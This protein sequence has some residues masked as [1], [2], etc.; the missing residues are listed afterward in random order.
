M[1]NMFAFYICDTSGFL[2]IM[3]LVKLVINFIRYIVP[4]ILI[5]MTIFDLVK[6]V[7]NP[8]EKDGMNKIIKRAVAAILVF[9]VPAIV[10]ATINLLNY[11]LENSGDT[12]YKV[13][14]CYT[15]A[16]LTCI[17]KIDDYLNCEGLSGD[18]LLNCKRFRQC[19]SYRLVGDCGIVT[20]YDNYS[21]SSINQNSQYNMYSQ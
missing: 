10:G 12:D 2:R 20:E 11:V 19:N 6:N 3:Y 21:C 14:S 13:S 15:N 17:N 18:A 5:V 4:M 16:N 1:F 9:I 7:I 8:K